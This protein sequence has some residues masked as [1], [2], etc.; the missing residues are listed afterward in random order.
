MST[1]VRRS[2]RSKARVAGLVACAVLVGLLVVIGI[3]IAS[4]GENQP[5][6]EAQAGPRVPANSCLGQV[7]G[8]A[9]AGGAAYYLGPVYRGAPAKPQYGCGWPRWNARHAQIAYFPR[10]DA[11]NDGPG[12]IKFVVIVFTVPRDNT[13]VA[14]FYDGVSSRMPVD[15]DMDVVLVFQRVDPSADLIRQTRAAVQPILTDAS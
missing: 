13:S 5:G 4:K 14:R 9:P 2:T 7:A 12:G 6:G 10:L 8:K 11:A 1:P 15:G 3:V